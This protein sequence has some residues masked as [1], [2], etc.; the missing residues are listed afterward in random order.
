MESID[1]NF[2]AIVRFADGYGVISGY[3]DNGK[4]LYGNKMYIDEGLG[5]FP[6]SDYSIIDN[7]IIINGVNPEKTT[8][9]LLMNCL[10]W[11]IHMA[12]LPEFFN[13]ENNTP[14]VNGIAC[15]DK[16]IEL[17]QN[18][19]FFDC[20]KN[21]SEEKMKQLIYEHSR[22]KVEKYCDNYLHH[23][24]HLIEEFYW[25]F[26]QYNLNKRRFAPGFLRIMA[27]EFDICA[28]ELEKAALEYN[29]VYKLYTETDKY[30]PQPYRGWTEEQALRFKDSNYRNMLIDVLLN[31]KEHEKTGIS[32]M[33]KAFQKISTVLEP[34]KQQH[35]SGDVN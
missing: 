29:E 16:I 26:I 27:K 7:V 19:A 24:G 6:R 28:D 1:N 34:N 10:E 18:E 8:K 22:V 3:D 4:Q 31:I 35:A 23:L 21:Y 25:D 20:E 12:T 15:Y 2:P 30:R 5:Y 13:Y 32:Y 14:C 11:D 17:L 9:N 33:Q